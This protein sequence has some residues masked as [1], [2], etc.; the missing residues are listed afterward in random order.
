MALTLCCKEAWRKSIYAGKCRLRLFGCPITSDFSSHRAQ[1]FLLCDLGVDL[2][3]HGLD[4]R[5]DVG[6]VCFADRFQDGFTV[7]CR[8]VLPEFPRM[9]RHAVLFKQGR[10]LLAVGLGLNAAL[11]ILALCSSSITRFAMTIS[12][13]VGLLNATG[14]WC[15]SQS[16]FLNNINLKLLYCQGMTLSILGLKICPGFFIRPKT[17][18]SL[19]PIYL[20]TRELRWY[21]QTRESPRV[22]RVS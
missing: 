17:L 1:V 11:S 13:F 22:A 9:K 21:Y 2:R 3:L 16:Y 10:S 6:Q 8:D 7:W 12:C 5:V 20:Q 4:V 14:Q 18:R 15:E 19:V